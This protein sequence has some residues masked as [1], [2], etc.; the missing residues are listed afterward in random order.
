MRFLTTLLLAGAVVLGSGQAL[1]A[2]CKSTEL[3]GHMEQL[4][5]NL[6]EITAAVRGNRLPAAAER[7]ADAMAAV[8]ASIPQTPFALSRRGLSGEQLEQAQAEYR[9]IAMELRELFERLEGAVQAGDRA[10][11]LAILNDISDLRRRGHREF[12][13]SSCS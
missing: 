12:K 13:D 5:D 1:A 10:Q 3:F 9:T 4:R 11:A 8:E 6:R 7:M 2:D